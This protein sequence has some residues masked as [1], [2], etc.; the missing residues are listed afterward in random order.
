M[1]SAVSADTTP[2]AY[3]KTGEG[4]PVIIVGGSLGDHR[5]YVPLATELATGFTVYNFDRRGRGQSGDCA[6]YAVA[7]EVEDIA[8]L[9]DGASQPVFVYGH[10]AGS[11]LALHAAAAGLKITKL[12]LADPPF[13]PHSNSDEEAKARQAEEAAKI[14]AL[15]DAG[16]HRGAAAFFLSGFGLPAEAVEQMLDSPAGEAMIDCARALPYDYAVVGDALVPNALATRATMPTLIL[17][18][19]AAPRTGAALV[20]AMPNARLQTMRASAH[21]L[22]ASEIATVIIPFFEHTGEH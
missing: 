13:R 4:P 2:I 9:I 1:Q 6:P 12:V 21:D 14:Q 18:D 11:A 22:D 20:E 10:S 17:A 5:F 7:R 19:Q 16:D 8:S 15:H 3:E